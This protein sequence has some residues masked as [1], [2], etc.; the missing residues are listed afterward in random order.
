MNEQHS[1]SQFMLSGNQANINY[2]YVTEICSGGR[3]FF[4]SYKLKPKKQATLWTSRP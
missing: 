1:G 3:L 4:E 2:I